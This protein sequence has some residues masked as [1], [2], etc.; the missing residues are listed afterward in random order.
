MPKS[1]GTHCPLLNKAC[2]EHKCAWYTQVAGTDPNTGQEISQFGCAIGWMPLLVIESARQ[3]RST[4]AAT[5]SF[6]NEMV[7][8]QKMTFQV[9]DAATRF[10]GA[11]PNEMLP[12]S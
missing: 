8:A 4:A 11:P 6:R 10:R 2:I 9:I 7:N 1:L 5:E 3:Q 12:P